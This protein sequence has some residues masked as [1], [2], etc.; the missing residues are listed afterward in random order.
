MKTA[1]LLSLLVVLLLSL[2]SQRD[3]QFARPSSDIVPPSY[4]LAA[5]GRRPFTLVRRMRSLGASCT[6]QRCCCYYLAM[7]KCTRV[8]THVQMQIV[9]RGLQKCINQKGCYR[10]QWLRCTVA[11]V[12][13]ETNQGSSPLPHHL[14][15][16]Q[17]PGN[18]S[19]S[20]I[21]ASTENNQRDGK[22]TSHAL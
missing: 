11:H 8:Q 14:A 4:A 13:C 9:L 10:L 19:Q 22:R 15:L 20:I 5:S 21:I 3:S 18:K 1:M 17:V 16:L 6:L 7:W 12:M 2:H